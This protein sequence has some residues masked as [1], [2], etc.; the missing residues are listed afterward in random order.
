MNN[1][2]N[3]NK[4]M[5]EQVCVYCASS[6][7]VHENFKI[8]AR[9]LGKILA[10]QNITIKYGGGSAGLMGEVADAA[11]SNGGKVIGIIPHFMF[12]LE[13]GHK[14]LTELHLVDDLHQRKKMMIQD[15]DA[16][17]SLPGGTGTFEEMFEAITL[18]RLG[19]YPKPIVILN[20][21]NF[22]QPLFELLH[23]C[24]TENFLNEKHLEMWSVVEEPAQV[25]PAINTSPQWPL[26]AHEF[27]AVKR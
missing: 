6:N 13:W 18:K 2:Y 21:N 8:A 14:S 24:V 27:A 12:D 25:I 23:N 22:Y 20:T 11:L 3:W 9:N 15:T 19:L 17:I 7:H 5:I 10:E 16:V 26:N 4:S 1:F